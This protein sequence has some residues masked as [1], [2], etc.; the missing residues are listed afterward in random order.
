MRAAAAL[1]LLLLL[2]A[3]P[4]AAAQAIHVD[5]LLLARYVGQYALSANYTL[6]ILVDRDRLYVRAP[7]RGQR[8]L[9]P[10]S[11]PS[12]SR[13]NPASASGSGSER[14]LAKWT[15]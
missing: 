4:P 15:T 7:T 14:T 1:V 10:T 11:R 5:P 8:L 9:V 13:S 3:P 12:S 2:P 6:T